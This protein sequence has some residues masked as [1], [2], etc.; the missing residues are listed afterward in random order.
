[1]LFNAKNIPF[2]LCSFYK[3]IVTR[4]TSHFGIETSKIEQELYGIIS[5]LVIMEIPDTELSTVLNEIR[6]L[7]PKSLTNYSK[8]TW[9]LAALSLNSLFIAIFPVVDI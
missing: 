1:M 7:D 6:S 4:Q 3:N 8:P 5:V 2:P 9:N